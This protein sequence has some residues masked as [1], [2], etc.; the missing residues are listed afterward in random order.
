MIK[1]GLLFPG[2]GAQYVGMG[3]ELYDSFSQAKD[4]FDHS[5]D[6]LGYN[7]KKIIFEGP[8]ETL[9]QTKYTQPAIFVTSLAVYKVFFEKIKLDDSIIISAGHSL[10]EYSSF[11]AAGSFDLKTGLNLVKSRGEFIQLASENNPGTMAA[12]I[13]LDRTQVENICRE[14]K[15]SG[16]CDAVNFNSPGQIVIAGSNE[17]INKAVELAQQ[18]GATKS[19]ILNVSGPFHSSLMT[20]AAENMEKEIIKYQ[21]NKPRFPV[22]TNYDAQ[23]TID[24]SLI[25]NKLIKQIN[26]P[27]LWED[28]I[29]KMMEI[30]CEYFVELG[31]G[32]VLSGLLR[33]IDKTKKTFNIE[34]IS[35]LEKTC[36]SIEQ[37]IK[38][39]V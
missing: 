21:F 29:R 34:D 28:S 2:Q 38:Q 22:V 33:K 16:V 24:E 27:V 37:V 3:K 7:L 13:G 31:P 14:S 10:G 32:R 25:P 17:S 8:Q 30:G 11:A 36:C 12:I 1:I 26:N 19:V 35:S 9:K 4:I 20:Q 23:P 6:I 39:F 18:L 15:N 5:D